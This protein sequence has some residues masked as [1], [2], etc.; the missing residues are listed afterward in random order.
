MKKQLL[1][2]LTLGLMT[3]MMIGCAKPADKSDAKSNAGKTSKVSTSRHSHTYDETRWEYDDETHWHPAT[4]E[5]TDARGSE[6]EHEFVKDETL[7]VA[8]TCAKE[9]K[10]VEKCK[11]GK[12]RETVI[13]ADA[14][15]HVWGTPSKTVEKSETTSAYKIQTCSVCNSIDLCVDAMSYL[16][17]GSTS[18]DPWGNKDSSGATLKMSKNGNFVK[19]KFNL[20]QAFTNAKVYLYGW[21]DYF[22]DGQN[23]NH[24]KGHLVNGNA[25]FSLTVGETAVEVTN[26]KSFVDMGMTNSGE[27]DGSGHNRGTF[28]MCELGGLATL[29]A[30]DIE[31]TYARVGS[32]N[33]NITE[34]HFVMAGK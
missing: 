10:L 17:T 11:C 23:N 20:E 9:G 6:E 14:N 25:T 31:L 2:G 8:A 32:Y 27:D 26:D 18:S 12:T 19:Y 34:I 21:V 22:E 4:C 33:L 3:F 1:S 24:L 5:H 30:G 16:E 7:S 15:H 28:T 13:A 29:A